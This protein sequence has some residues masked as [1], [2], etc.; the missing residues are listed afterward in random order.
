MPDDDL[1]PYSWRSDPKE[2]TTTS[3][4]VNATQKIASS[5]DKSC[6]LPS[7]CNRVLI[8]DAGDKA[9]DPAVLAAMR[10]LE[11]SLDA[12]VRVHQKCTK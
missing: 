12:I 2:S 1:L 5:A 8:Q 10:K 3:S 7:A 4:Y 9:F 6:C 11:T